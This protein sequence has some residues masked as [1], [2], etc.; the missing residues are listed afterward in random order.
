[1]QY[2]F[3]IDEVNTFNSPNLK[4]SGWIKHYARYKP[5]LK[6]NTQYYWRVKVR[7]SALTPT[8]SSYTS[9]WSFTTRGPTSWYVRNLVDIDTTW[10]VLRNPIADPGIYGSQDGSS[11][12]NA[13]NGIFSIKWGEGGV[14]AGDTLYVCGTHIYNMYYTYW[15]SPTSARIKESG[16]SDEYPITITTACPDEQGVIWGESRD[17]TVS[18]TWTGP[19]ANGVY[20][21]SDIPNAAVE[22]NGTD[23]I[24]LDRETSTTWTGHLG[25]S[26]TTGGVTYVKTSDLSSP[27]GKI[28]SSYWFKFGFDMGRS[29][30][31][32]FKDYKSF[33]SVVGKNAKSYSISEL[34]VSKNITFEDCEFAY[35]DGD[36][37]SI[38]EGMDNWI[39]R[40]CDL[41][42]MEN[43]I[44]TH[45]PGYVYNLLVENNRI[46]NT[47]PPNYGN[48]DCH[49]VGI[50]N[51]ANHIIQNNTIW[52]TGGSAIEFWASGYTMKN[53]TIRNNFIKDTRTLCGTSG[54]GIIVSGSNEASWGKRTGFKIYNNIV[55]NSGAGAPV[56]W[57]GGNGIASNNKDPVDVYNN[58]VVN[59]FKNG[60]DFVVINPDGPP[61]GKIY[62][63]IIVNPGERYVTMTGIGDWSNFSSDYN[64]YYPATDFDT[65]FFFTEVITRD[66]N[67]ILA[68]PL[69]VSGSPENAEDFKLQA[70]SLAIDAGIDVG[71]LFD[72]E[73]VSIP[74]LFGLLEVFEGKSMVCCFCVGSFCVDVFGGVYFSCFF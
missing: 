73:G 55:V 12:A 70:G 68:D 46:Y 16:F 47:G 18:V 71:T 74:Q 72:F 37:I 35:Y 25:A 15:D 1:L 51:G 28:Y 36:L 49:A 24:K 2:Y 34:D 63:N 59:P 45:T 13:F 40:N 9:I 10:D 19:D 5:V 38:T 54:G 23:Y 66:T 14:E 62:N 67:S 61:Q 21:T 4:E 53:M 29:D 57:W 11:Y 39:I 30:F 52:N 58:I 7:D 64:L 6:P 48:V 50:Q 44:Y 17:M 27:A 60:I 42:D 33:N 22:F 8:G 41:H 3:Q 65:D 26:Y 31:I 43:G 69:F 20:S 56:W 32:K